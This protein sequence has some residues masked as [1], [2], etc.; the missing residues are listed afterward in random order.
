[1]SKS[2]QK[3]GYRAG[4]G[5]P[6]FRRGDPVQGSQL[7][8]LRRFADTG[9]VAGAGIRLE[10][11]GGQLVISIDENF[12]RGGGSSTAKTGSWSF[13]VAAS[14]AAL[15]SNAVSP[16]LGF[17]DAGGEKYRK[18][19]FDDDTSTWYCLNFLEA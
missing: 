9:I 13:H 17:V 18:Y 4:D 15:P 7:E 1:M 8:E 10:K 16:A 6:H 11:V 12:V 2:G 3:A 5:K 19:W 14:K